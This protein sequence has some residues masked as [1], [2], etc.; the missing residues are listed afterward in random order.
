MRSA[1]TFIHF[2]SFSYFE[3]FKRNSIGSHFLK[4]VQRAGEFLEI[5]TGSV[6]CVVPFFEKRLGPSKRK[7]KRRKENREKTEAK[8]YLDTSAPLEV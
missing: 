3:L 1:G 6:K 8:Q 7:K 5:L 4:R 2:L